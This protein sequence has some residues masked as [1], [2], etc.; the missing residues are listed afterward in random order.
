MSNNPVSLVRLW[1]NAALVA[2]V[3][4]AVG[5]MFLAAEYWNGWPWL[6]GAVAFGFAALSFAVNWRY[7]HKSDVAWDEQNVAAHRAS[8]VFGYWATLAVF[9]LLLGAV[10]ADIME[11]RAAVFWMGIPLG[12]APSVHYLA[13][14]LRGRAE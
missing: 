4:T 12:I 1:G 5:S 8:L 7:P 14:V 3:M 11:A 2:M 10:L 6:I 13:S 9:L